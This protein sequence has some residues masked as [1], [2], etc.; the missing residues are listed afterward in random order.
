VAKAFGA[1]SIYIS[2]VNEEK[3]AFA[4]DFLDCATFLVNPK[5]AALD[6]ARRLTKQMDLPRGVDTVLECTGVESSIQIGLHASAAGATFV[7]IGMGKPE[8]SLPLGAMM[9]KEIVLKTSFRY[10]PDDYNIA[11][12]LLNSRK[13]NLGSMISS[14]VPFDQAATAWERTR[15][16]EGIKNLIEGVKSPAAA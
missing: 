6:E 16:G 9:E 4:Q 1:K 3:L 13:V 15:R 7:Q 10:G 8:Q 11:V 2:D 12:E 5:S 14:I